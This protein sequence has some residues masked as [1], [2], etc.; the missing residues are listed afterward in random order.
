M[1]LFDRGYLMPQVIT[2]VLQE[3]PG[4]NIHMEVANSSLLEKLQR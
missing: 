4:L 3:N 1:P 2:R